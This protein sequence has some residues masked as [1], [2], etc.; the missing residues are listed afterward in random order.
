MSVHWLANFPIAMAQR[1]WF[2]RNPLVSQVILS[3]WVFACFAVAVA[4]MARLLFPEVRIGRMLFGEAVCPECG[5]RYERGVFTGLNV[6]SESALRA[7]PILS[8][9]AL[10]HRGHVLGCRRGA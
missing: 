5:Q 7:M 4:W 10:V 3:L 8:A 9:L 1:G 6:G 2:G